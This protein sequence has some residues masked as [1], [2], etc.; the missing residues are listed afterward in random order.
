MIRLITSDQRGSHLPA[1]IEMHRLRYRVFKERLDWEVTTTADQELDEFDTLRPVYLLHETDEGDVDGCVRL[2]PTTGPYML[3]EVFPALLRDQPAPVT[4]RIWEASRFAYEVDPKRGP[5]RRGLAG[6]TIE[7]F[8]AMIEF[9]LD[10]SL[11]EF[12]AVV[13]VRMERILRMAD[14]PL[15]RI[16]PTHWIGRTETTAGYLEIS[17]AALGRVR[18]HGGIRHPLL[19]GPENAVA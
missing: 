13:D 11:D 2:L 18:E 7:L 15:R 9:G 6:P 12:V 4:H 14:W 19:P 17:E 8:A 1:L 3:R 5:C 10:W 16:G